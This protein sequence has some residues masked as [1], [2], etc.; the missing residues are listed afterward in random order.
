MFWGALNLSLFLWFYDFLILFWT[1]SVCVFLIFVFHFNTIWLIG[2][3][4]SKEDSPSWTDI[5]YVLN[6]EEIKHEVSQITILINYLLLYHSVVYLHG[7]IAIRCWY[8][9]AVMHLIHFSKTMNVEKCR[10]EI[11]TISIYM[12]IYIHCNS[13]WTFLFDT[14]I[15]TLPLVM[16]FCLF[17]VYILE[18]D[19]IFL[20]SSKP[21]I[22]FPAVQTVDHP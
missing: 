2:C 9:S 12:Y 18:T 22:L 20:Y 17:V 21:S 6:S 13:H 3:S 10:Y 11:L 8:F 7:V 16:T 14:I 19:E 15:F 1:V 5:T 4:I